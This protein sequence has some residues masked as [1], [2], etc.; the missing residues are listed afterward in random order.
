MGLQT[1]V[2]LD[3]CF[4]VGIHRPEFGVENLREKD[5]PAI[6]GKLG[7]G[8]PV[9]NQINFPQGRVQETGADLI[10]EIANASQ[11]NTGEKLMGVLER[12]LDNVVY[13]LGLAHAFGQL[14]V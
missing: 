10:Y 4:R 7:D 6:L 11:A 13:R 5:F 8:T 14:L 2:G 1:C 9:D 12:R 3:G